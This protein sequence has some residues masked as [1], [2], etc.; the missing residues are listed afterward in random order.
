MLIPNLLFHVV[1]LYLVIYFMC[2]IKR[3]RNKES[4]KPSN[5]PNYVEIRMGTS[6]SLDEETSFRTVSGA[7]LTTFEK[8]FQGSN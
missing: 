4:N 2:F 7:N 6:F 3:I 8:L 5:N 1:F